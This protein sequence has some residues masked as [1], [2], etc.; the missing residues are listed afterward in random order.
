VLFLRGEEGSALSAYRVALV[1]GQ[2]RKILDDVLEADWSPDGGRIAFLRPRVVA[3]QKNWILGVVDIRGGRE[4]TLAEVKGFELLSLRWSPDGRTI[5]V[6]QTAEV[7]FSPGDRLLLVDVSGGK[8]RALFPNQPSLPVGGLAWS[9]PGRE[10][11]FGQAGS[12]MGDSAGALARVIRRH[13]ASGRERTLFWAPN[14]FP[15]IGATKEHSSFD[16]LGPGRL[17]FDEIAQRLNLR[18]CPIAPDLPQ[19]ADRVFTEGSSRDRQPSY[20][21]DGEHIVFSSNRSGNL[22]LWAL[23]TRTG[24]L[25]QLTDDPAQDWDPGFTPDGEHILWSSDR[26]GNLEIWIADADGSGARQLSRDGEDA[27][28]PTA[29]PDG[30]WV[31]FA[32][33]DPGK[34][35]IWK[36]RPD[37]SGAERLVPG[38][39][40][41]AEVS[42]DGRFTSFLSIGAARSSNTITIAVVEIATG[43]RIAFEIRVP[44][45]LSPRGSRVLVG[46][47]RWLP[48]GK[49]I[50]FVGEDENGLTGVFAQDFVPGK[51]TSS[52]RRKL[53]GFSLE[54]ISESFG[55]S[56]DGKRLMLSTLTQFES[57]MLAEG[58]EGVEPPDRRTDAARAGDR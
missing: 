8:V 29:T 10:L 57:L 56:P 53:A 23:S 19:R 35:G 15:T 33:G 27:E 58:V 44:F 32:S 40:T 7:G 21:P 52:T 24:A 36:I 45:R 43:R 11:V 30:A 55:I 14:L 20:S 5:G 42:P 1:G 47:S 41:N 28:N 49:A 38:S 2:P 12:R 22:D 51:D 48:D 34:N 16:V 39:F 37:G 17:V 26:S 13:L 4:T 6:V 3:S 31:A 46:R 18:E 9:G 25:K 50:A 54:Y